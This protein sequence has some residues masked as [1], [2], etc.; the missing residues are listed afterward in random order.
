MDIGEKWFQL[1]WTSHFLTQIWLSLWWL[2]YWITSFVC[3]SN[4]SQ[5]VVELAM[6]CYN[7]VQHMCYS[8]YV[9]SHHHN[10]FHS[11]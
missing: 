5:Q 8:Y 10:C 7:C 6:D 9:L 1:K 2:Y 4:C 11:C 3:F